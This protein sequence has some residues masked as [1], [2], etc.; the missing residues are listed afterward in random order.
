[1]ARDGREQRLCVCTN[2]ALSLVWAASSRPRPHLHLRWRGSVMECRYYRR[3]MDSADF[4]SGYLRNQCNP[5]FRF[6]LQISPLPNQNICAN[7]LSSQLPFSKWL[8]Y[9]L[10]E[11]ASSRHRPLWRHESPKEYLNIGNG[12]V[13]PARKNCSSM[14]WV[15]IRP[16]FF[17]FSFLLSPPWVFLCVPL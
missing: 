9:F 6:P 3:W 4:S 8:P 14:F 17:A 13:M 12:L 7:I 16:L 2:S 15:N 5:R 1:M 11:A 10:V